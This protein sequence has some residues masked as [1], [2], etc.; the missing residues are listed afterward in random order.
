MPTSGR[1]LVNGTVR[2]QPDRHCGYVPQRYSLFPDKTVLDNVMFGLL[3][4]S[5]I[6]IG[7]FQPQARDS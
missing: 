4:T 3:V 1:V 6:G 2:T 5:K 7:I